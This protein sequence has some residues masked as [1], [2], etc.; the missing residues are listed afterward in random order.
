MEVRKHEANKEVMAANAAS[1]PYM[2]ERD[3]TSYVQA[4]RDRVNGV[5]PKTAE[6]LKEE[7]LAE[8]AANRKSFIAQ[9]G[10]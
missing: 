10:G 4:L 3:R 5:T 7:K 2:S 8:Q 6:Q 9:L 1:A